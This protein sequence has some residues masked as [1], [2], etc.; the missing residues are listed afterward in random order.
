MIWRTWVHIL[1]D[2]IL[3]G[4][5]GSGIE[6]WMHMVRTELNEYLSQLFIISQSPVPYL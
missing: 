3:A 6:P 2:E 4:G 1:T 5:F